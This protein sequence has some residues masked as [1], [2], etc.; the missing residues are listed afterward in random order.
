LFKAQKKDFRTGRPDALYSP[1][2]DG[3][4]R[5]STEGH[6]LQRATLTRVMLSD[7]GR[8]LPLLAIGIVA[9]AV[10]S[11]RRAA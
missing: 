1:T 3:S 8:A 9:A 4:R 5:G 7:A 10:A 2:R 11:R 6:E